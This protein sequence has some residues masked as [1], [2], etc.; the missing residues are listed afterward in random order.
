MRA[1]AERDFTIGRRWQGY[2][3][4]DL[5]FLR[6]KNYRNHDYSNGGYLFGHDD[7][8]TSVGISPVAGFRSS[9]SVPEL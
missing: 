9:W 8:E 7:K 4:G 1:G 3:G 5:K 2:A 6:L